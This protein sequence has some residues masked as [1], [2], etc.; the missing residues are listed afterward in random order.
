[1]NKFFMTQNN[2]TPRPRKRDGRN[3]GGQRYANARGVT[4]IEL[5]VSIVIVAI[6]VSGILLVMSMTSSHSADPMLRQQALLIAES[7]MEEI[8]AQKFLNPTA[9]PPREVAG[10]SAYN[11]VCDYANLDSTSGSVATNGCNTPTGGV[12]DRQGNTIAGLERYNVF[13]AVVSSGVTLG[14]TANLVA[15]TVG[16]P[17]RIRVLRITVR[18]THD[19]FSDIDIPL[20]AYRTNYL[21]GVGG[22]GGK[23]GETCPAS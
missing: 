21:C 15:N 11:N 8:L 5:I 9:C 19:D 12:C 6:A 14:P 22:V 23:L 4:F 13:A 17:V 18:V 3:G 2:L 16:P 10:R 7:Y 1:M 20:T